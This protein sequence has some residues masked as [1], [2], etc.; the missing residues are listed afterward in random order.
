[1][2]ACP[3]M[4]HVDNISTEVFKIFLIKSNFYPVPPS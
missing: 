3:Q 2:G 1:M 4:T